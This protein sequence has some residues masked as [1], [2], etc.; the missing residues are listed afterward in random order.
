MT[1]HQLLLEKQIKNRAKII[2]F[3]HKNKLKMV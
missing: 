2:Y 1:E 3:L